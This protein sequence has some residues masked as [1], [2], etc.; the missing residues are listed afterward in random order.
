MV[1]VAFEQR[2]GRVKEQAMWIYGWK[3]FRERETAGTK[4]LWW[5]YAWEY[6]GNM[7]GEFEEQ[8]TAK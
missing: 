3:A 2:S 4:A 1:K 8:Q 7:L 5:E 6:D